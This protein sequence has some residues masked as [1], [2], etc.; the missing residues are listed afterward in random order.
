MTVG[1]IIFSRLDSKRLPG[2]ALLDISG[3][4]MLGRVID[5]AKSIKGVDHIIVATSSRSI[6]D[7]IVSFAKSEN[8][9][10]F[11][12]SVD[13]VGERAL[14][15]CDKFGLTKFAR[16]CGDRPFFAPKVISDLIDMHNE[17]NVDITTTMFP[18][19]YPPG[20]TGEVVTTLALQ[21]AMSETKEASD[22]EHITSYFYRHSEKFSIL[23]LD[24]PEDIDLNGLHLVVDD[25]TDLERVRWIASQL[26]DSGEVFS[27]LSEVVRLAREWDCLQ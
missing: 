4:P 10:I 27:D 1:V 17:S 16:I 22:V 23:N 25:K 11:R 3:R 20:L 6:D 7:P 18:R 14:G 15:V 13:N 9:E 8:V 26:G 12:G 5:R 2:K 24:P 21:K 19:S